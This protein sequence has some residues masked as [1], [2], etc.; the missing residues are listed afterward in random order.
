[1]KAKI[2]FARLNQSL[3]QSLLQTIDIILCLVIALLSLLLLQLQFAQR[4]LT[5]FQFFTNFLYV[6]DGLIAFSVQP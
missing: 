6:G 1:M 2:Y 4:A 5:S 3:V